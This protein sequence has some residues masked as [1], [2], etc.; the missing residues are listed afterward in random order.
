MYFT[1]LTVRYFT[2][3]NSGKFLFEDIQTSAISM[4]SGATPTGRKMKIGFTGITGQTEWAFEFREGK[5]YDPQGKWFG[6]YD[7]DT[8]LSISGNFNMSSF[9]YYLNGELINAKGTK[10]DN[11]FNGWF[12]ECF[13]GATGQASVFVTASP[14]SVYLKMKSGFYLNNYW[15]GTFQHV[16][17]FPLVIRSGELFLPDSVYFQL[18]GTGLSFN[19]GKN[20]LGP[21]EYRTVVLEQ[22]G[23]SPVTGMYTVGIR[24]YT[25]YGYSEFVVSGSG[26]ST[27]RG[28]IS[29]NLEPATG[30]DIVYSGTEN[31]ASFSYAFSSDYIDFEGNQLSKPYIVMLEYVSGYTGTIY[32]ASSGYT[33]SDQGHDY[34]G[35]PYILIEPTG[36]GYPYASGRGTIDS[37]GH[38]VGITWDQEGYYTG[39]T[40]DYSMVLYGGGGAG[41]I[42]SVDW[43][44]YSYDKLFGSIMECSTG[45]FGEENTALTGNYFD[46]YYGSGTLAAS[47]NIIDV[48][49]SVVPYPDTAQIL[50]RLKASG[51]PDSNSS[52]SLFTGSG[53]AYRILVE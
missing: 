19:D 15:S 10:V 26:V 53:L 52:I 20:V 35:S 7:E 38:I 8:Y 11:E 48:T 9:N 34:A 4:V 1:G 28:T 31:G 51:L 23:S 42:G 44:V 27:S 39:N 21:G 50:Y 41:F 22:T 17:D 29:N 49:V 24:V 30:Q 46:V 16:H 25:D 33:I 14:I 12:V 47:E 18:Y 5:I 36:G 45:I 13:S 2:A 6:A 37:E 32:A 43:G 40:N 3:T